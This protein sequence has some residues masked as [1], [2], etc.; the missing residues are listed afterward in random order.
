MWLKWGQKEST[1][2]INAQTEADQT[3]TDKENDNLF[4]NSDLNEDE[5]EGFHI[6]DEDALA[7][8]ENKGARGAGASAVGMK[9]P[10]DKSSNIVAEKVKGRFYPSN[11]PIYC[12][13]I[14]IIFI[15]VYATKWLFLL[16]CIVD[17]FEKDASNEVKSNEHS[18]HEAP[19]PLSNDELT[20]AI[21]RM[22]HLVLS[23]KTLFD[24]KC[25]PR[26][27][28]VLA[29]DIPGKIARLSF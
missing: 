6:L 25:Q 7:R 28:S 27:S 23:V 17:L 1:N 29:Y 22:G 14:V 2:S 11:S 12:I 15:I 18:D 10:F 8:V 26:S 24:S 16:S 5:D 9:V 3:G 19:P 13:N 21:E 4:S 20:T